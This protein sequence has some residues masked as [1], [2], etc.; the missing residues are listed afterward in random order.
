MCRYFVGTINC[1]RPKEIRVKHTIRGAFEGFKQLNKQLKEP[2][3]KQVR[4][5]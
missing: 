1:E 2:T 4:F 3:K 5:Q